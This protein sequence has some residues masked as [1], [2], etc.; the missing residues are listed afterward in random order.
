M[1]LAGGERPVA[2]IL[3][4]LRHQ[5]PG[6]ELERGT[7]QR[8]AT[9]DHRPTRQTGGKGHRALDVGLVEHEATVDNAI[10]VRRPDVR[11]AQ[12]TEGVR[13]L[14]VFVPML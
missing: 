6:V 9:H 1:P 14:V 2:G 4:H 10:H 12:S 5:H 11:V 13:S 7:E 3:E 8:L